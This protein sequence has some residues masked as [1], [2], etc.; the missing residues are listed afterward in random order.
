M[1]VLCCAGK[2]KSKDKH[3]K[4]KSSK[5]HNKDKDKDKDHKHSKKV[6][7][8]ACKDKMQCAVTLRYHAVPADRSCNCCHF[9]VCSALQAAH[10][11]I[12]FVGADSPAS[13][14]SPAT[15]HSNSTTRSPRSDGT[16]TPA[17]TAI[18]A[19]VAAAAAQTAGNQAVGSQ[20]KRPKDPS[21]SANISNL[22]E[23]DMTRAGCL[24]HSRLLLQIVY[25]IVYMPLCALK[26]YA[27]CMLN[28]HI[29]CCNALCNIHGTEELDVNA[30][31]KCLTCT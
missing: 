15:R 18:A 30:M 10:G 23:P 11:P 14:D 21:S 8:A 25:I 9:T 26:H 12:H 7:A 3:H 5:K 4:S 29:P 16:Q 13:A 24:L 28:I 22:D 17:A 31:H 6:C 1:L 20:Q 2:H 19:A 27:T